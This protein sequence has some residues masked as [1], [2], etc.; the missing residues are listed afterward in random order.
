MNNDFE[1]LYTL[2]DDE[3]Y[4]KHIKN[5]YMPLIIHYSKKYSRIGLKLGYQY[6]D[7][8]QEGIIILYT[9]IKS[10]NE[11]NSLFYTYISRLLRNGYSTLIRINSTNKKRSLN[12][13]I[14]IDNKIYDNLTIKDIIE[15][16]R[17]DFYKKDLDKNI[18]YERHKLDLIE[19]SIL[20]LKI[21]GYRDYEII[22]LLSINYS[23]FKS[24]ILKIKD[25]LLTNKVYF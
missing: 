6:E 13:S 14:S 10:Y 22:K 9:A 21:E 1:I 24:K 15:D 4:F 3:L 12:E 8:I 7:L 16:K 18:V 20:D 5:K 2:N 17:I 25:F 11:A 23:I 19:T